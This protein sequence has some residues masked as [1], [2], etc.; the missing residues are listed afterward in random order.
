MHELTLLPRI[1]H[2]LVVGLFLEAQDALREELERTVE[3]GL[4]RAHRPGARRLRAGLTVKRRISGRRSAPCGASAQR[5]RLRLE[6]VE[7]DRI[8][9][10]RLLHEDPFARRR[11]AGDGRQ[12]GAGTSST[13]ATT[14]TSASSSSVMV[15][16]ATRLRRR[17][18][19]I[20]EARIRR[21]A[22]VLLRRPAQRLQERRANRRCSAA[23]APAIH[24]RS[25][26]RSSSGRSR[27]SGPRDR[28]RAAD[29]GIASFQRDRRKRL[30]FNRTPHREASAVD[31]HRRIVVRTARGGQSFERVDD[32]RSRPAFARGSPASAGRSS[33]LVDVSARTEV[34]RGRR[35]RFAG[36]DSTRSI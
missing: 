7:R 19:Q 10:E 22:P 35:C 16:S 14:S 15:E 28:R 11:V 29:V 18:Q 32:R 12:A 5:S 21:A 36:N 2:L 25:G 20:E 1:H 23:D 9:R 8:E 33:A 26:R 13:R 17:R 6:R 27:R 3:V 4:E 34:R 31:V 24:L 30:L